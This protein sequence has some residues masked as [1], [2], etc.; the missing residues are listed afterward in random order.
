MFLGCIITLATVI[1][2]D[3]RYHKSMWEKM[4]TQIYNLG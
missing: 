2:N 4:L 3:F 1:F